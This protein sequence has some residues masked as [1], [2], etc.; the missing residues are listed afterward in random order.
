MT[1]DVA[2]SAPGLLYVASSCISS[3]L[4]DVWAGP[5]S[6][7]DVF[8]GSQPAPRR[9]LHASACVAI[10]GCNMRLLARPLLWTARLIEH[11][12]NER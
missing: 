3:E 2:P 4:L 6:S 5:C 12:L 1:F 11:Y 8:E 10:A 9:F 7:D